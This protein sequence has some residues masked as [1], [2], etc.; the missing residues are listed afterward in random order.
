MGKTESYKCTTNLLQHNANAI[1]VFAD[2]ALMGD[3]PVL[4]NHMS[5]AVLFGLVYVAFGWFMRDRWTAS[6]ASKEKSSSSQ[7]LYFFLDTTLGVKTTIFQFVLLVALLSSYLMF[8]VGRDW[9]LD[10][11][12]VEDDNMSWRLSCF[13]FL[14]YLVCKIRD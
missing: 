4:T 7:F 13:F 14:S 8:S 5:M 12:R 9:L 3:I 2:S 11:V 6:G 1:M 10:S